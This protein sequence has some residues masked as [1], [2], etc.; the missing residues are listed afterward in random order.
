MA[1]SLYGSRI[2]KRPLPAMQNDSMQGKT[3]K[4]T[5]QHSLQQGALSCK[6][7]RWRK[8]PVCFGVSLRLDRL[9]YKETV[10]FSADCFTAEIVF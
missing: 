4:Q 9:H 5:G 7:Y 10:C 8:Q 1:A 3:M 2:S 6:T